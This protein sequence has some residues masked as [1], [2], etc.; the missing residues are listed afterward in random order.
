MKTLVDRFKGYFL[1][2]KKFCKNFVSTKFCFFT[3]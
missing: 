1:K 2:F 3:K